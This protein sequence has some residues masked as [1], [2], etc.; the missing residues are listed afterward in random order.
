[1]LLWHRCD[2]LRLIDVWR[3]LICRKTSQ[4]GQPWPKQV[5]CSR[6][7]LH[8]G[9]L[10][11]CCGHSSY[12]FYSRVTNIMKSHI[13][14]SELRQVLFWRFLSVTI[15]CRPSVDVVCLSSVTL[16]QLHQIDAFLRQ[17]KKCGLCQP[18]LP[19]FQELCEAID[20]QLFDKILLNEQ[21]LLRYLLPPS[22]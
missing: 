16:V 10:W 13:A 14:C 2:P 11:V 3:A 7:Q 19:P 21:H 17:N 9:P 6:I 1:M 5:R 4:N 15:C 12:W 22:V 20:D 18:D 8:C